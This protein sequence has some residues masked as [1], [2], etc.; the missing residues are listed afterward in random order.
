M[1]DTREDGVFIPL[2][3]SGRASLWLALPPPSSGI[4]MLARTGYPS[5][6]SGRGRS[7]AA[8]TIRSVCWAMPEVHQLE[9]ALPR[10]SVDPVSKRL[11]YATPYYLVDTSHRP[12]QR[13]QPSPSR[14]PGLQSAQPDSRQSSD[15]EDFVTAPESPVMPGKAPAKP[16]EPA[17]IDF[18]HI[19]NRLERFTLS[20][21]DTES[22]S[23]P[24]HEPPLDV[25]YPYLPE[26]SYSPSPSLRPSLF[27][28]DDYFPDLD[29]EPEA[30]DREHRHCLYS[31]TPSRTHN[32]SRSGSSP[33]PPPTPR[34]T[35]NHP[36]PDPNPGVDPY[37]TPT[38]ATA[39]TSTT[40]NQMQFTTLS[41]LWS[42]A[43]SN[44]TTTTTPQPPITFPSFPSFPSF[45]EFPP[46]GPPCLSCRRP[47]TFGR[48]ARSN[49]NG[50]A[51]RPFYRCAPCR[52]WVTWADLRG[53]DV[54][55]GEEVLGLY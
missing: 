13:P 49:T 34:P 15:D 22:S 31:S 5:P 29:S 18:K 6:R 25:F 24:G 42:S 32:S 17:S 2:Q 52:R 36:N 43:Q 51:Q 28:D 38:G 40:T 16:G 48:V 30:D 3:D 41:A 27:I 46:L 11:R 47:S 35:S 53:G 12:N 39:S 9:F 37:S 7:E 26:P 1:P 45:P 21:I 10:A 4:M 50:N 33:S 20:P 23:L 54:R 55:A 44:Q 14:D 8:Y 19:M